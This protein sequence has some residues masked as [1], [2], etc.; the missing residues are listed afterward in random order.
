MLDERQPHG[1]RGG[2]HDT[3]GA[4]V[5]FPVG[6]WVVSDGVDA[7]GN[8]GG[9]EPASPLTY[10]REKS[11]SPDNSECTVVFLKNGSE[12]SGWSLF[13]SLLCSFFAPV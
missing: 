12:F 13:V 5:C 3:P 1:P 7:D 6:A 8:I 10:T 2:L 11:K 4:R 9:I